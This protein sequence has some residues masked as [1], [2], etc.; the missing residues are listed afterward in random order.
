MRTV[1]GILLLFAVTCLGQV[2]ST[3]SLS[4]GIQLR[5]ATNSDKGNPGNLKTELKPASENSVYRIFRDESG[6]AV[7]AYELAVDPLPD[8]DHF[9]I[10]AKPADEVFAAKFPNAD[11]GKPTPTL[12]RPIESVPLV[13]G[14][15]LTIE[16]PTNPG[17]FEHR[18][19]TIHIGFI[20]K[21]AQATPRLRFVSLKV[22]ID[23]KPAPIYSSGAMVS[24]RYVMFYI[25]GRGG[26][27]FSTEPVETRPFIPA[28]MADGVTLKFTINN[29]AY[30]CSADAPILLDAERGQIWLYYDP[31]Y[32][33]TGNLTR[34]NRNPR[35]SGEF[36]TA[37]SDT[38]DLWL[39]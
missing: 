2:S 38:L 32:R 1:P 30:V 31:R 25:P 26:Y 21:G 33:L 9:Q 14:G 19:D 6:L 29:E 5:I 10:V 8:G 22:A 28:G 37:A 34:Q 23:G 15:R 11:G 39:H 18:T 4:N 16:I 7:Y 35:A 27:F 3:V 13:S 36:F 24:G 17:W 12:A 20:A